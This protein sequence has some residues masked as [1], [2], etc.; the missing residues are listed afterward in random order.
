MHRF[1]LLSLFIFC[2][3]GTAYKVSDIQQEKRLNQV[4]SNPYFNQ[5][6]KEYAYR[7]KITFMKK[8]MKGNFVVK[9]IDK[10]THRAVMI[11]DFGNTLFDLSIFNNEYTLH[12]AMPDLNKKVVVKT[13]AEDLQT[14][15][16]N[17]FEV[18]QHYIT[19]DNLVLKSDNISLVYPKNE[20]MFFT[21]LIHLKKNKIKTM[22]QFEVDETDFPKNI[23]IKHNHFNLS[24]ELIKVNTE[25]E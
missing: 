2:S 13:L 11:S 3:C 6:N 8:E 9:K 20:S 12:Y 7:F 19:K 22:N 16:Q 17:D 23:L 18:N 21:E 4:V 1:L 14:I 25:L 10:T 5:V 24:I 15:F